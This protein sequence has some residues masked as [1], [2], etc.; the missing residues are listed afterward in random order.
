MQHN[1]YSCIIYYE[2]LFATKICETKQIGYKIRSSRNSVT[3]KDGVGKVTMPLKLRYI[4]NTKKVY[5]YIYIYITRPE[6]N[7]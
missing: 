2:Y 4:S 5:K 6:I 1:L 7:K 3:Y